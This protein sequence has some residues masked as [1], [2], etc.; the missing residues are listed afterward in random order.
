MRE[1]DLK[2]AS[3]VA[4][5]MRDVADLHG[6]VRDGALAAVHRAEL[7]ALHAVA[8]DHH[9]RTD[10]ARQAAVDAA[11]AV[12]EAMATA[13]EA[14]AAFQ[15]RLSVLSA[16]HAESIHYNNSTVTAALAGN[17]IMQAVHPSVLP[18]MM[19][20]PVARAVLAVQLVADGGRGL[21]GAG[22]KPLRHWPSISVAWH[23][24]RRQQR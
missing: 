10:T 5:D 22:A 17:P 16:L 15:S 8:A 9:A 4:S 2:R 12:D 23:Q 7:V 1:T 14:L 18:K 6:A 21:V 24:H 11:T 3:D 13:R 19:P 20:V